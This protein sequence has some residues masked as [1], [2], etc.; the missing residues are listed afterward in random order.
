M[1]RCFR[2]CPHCGNTFAKMYI[3][4]EPKPDK[5]FY[6]VVFICEAEGCNWEWEEPLYEMRIIKKIQSPEYRQSH[7]DDIPAVEEE[8]MQRRAIQNERAKQYEKWKMRGLTE[9]EMRRK[10]RLQIKKVGGRL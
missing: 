6:L 4:E 9:W 1:E 3:K 10:L 2:R 8:I 5:P 7:I